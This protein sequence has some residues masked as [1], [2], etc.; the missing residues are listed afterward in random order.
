MMRIDECASVS[1]TLQLNP[2]PLG[3]MLP[4]GSVLELSMI[5]TSLVCV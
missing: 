2:A 3:L 4:R 5:E 1:R